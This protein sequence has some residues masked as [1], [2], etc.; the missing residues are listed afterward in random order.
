MAEINP[1]CALAILCLENYKFNALHST[2]LLFY[3]TQVLNLDL[4]N[5]TFNGHLTHI[6]QLSYAAVY[7][8]APLN[9]P[10]AHCLLIYAIFP[11]ADAAVGR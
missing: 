4:K 5:R 8:K 7:Q 1:S 2:C 10:E 6:G 11:A 9:I 3:V